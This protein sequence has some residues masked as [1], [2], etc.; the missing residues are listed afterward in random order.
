MNANSQYTGGTII[1]APLYGS[2]VDIL[3]DLGRQVIAEQSSYHFD[4]LN[5]GNR[6]GNNEHP[7]A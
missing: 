2:L 3:A 1:P 4:N 7:S 5:N 6:R